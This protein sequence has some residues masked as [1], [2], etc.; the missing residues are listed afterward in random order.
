[1]TSPPSDQ[2]FE[3]DEPAMPLTIQTTIPVLTTLLFSFSLAMIGV[4]ATV[5]DWPSQPLCLLN[6]ESKTIALWLWSMAA[7]FFLFS[8]IG[9][10]KAH[11]WDYYALPQERRDAEG[12]STKSSYKNRCSNFCWAW[13]KIAIL[14]YYFGLATLLLGISALFYAV[15]TFTTVLALVCLFLPW[16]VKI[17]DKIFSSNQDWKDRREKLLKSFLGNNYLQS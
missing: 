16:L 17:A 9:C 4:I 15:S 1:M 3:L 10:V 6:R 12:L 2:G 14:N 13:Y 8:V 7:F 5:K 11:A